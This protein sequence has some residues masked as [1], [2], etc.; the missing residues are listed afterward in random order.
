MPG[1]AEQLLDIALPITYMDTPARIR[2]HCPLQCIGSLELTPGRK[3]DRGQSE[4]QAFGRDGFCECP[5]FL[6][7]AGAVGLKGNGKTRAR[8]SSK[9]GLPYI[10]RFRVFSRL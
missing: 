6:L 9:S 8:N 3:L 4:R 2:I 1:D 10:C 5:V 7:D